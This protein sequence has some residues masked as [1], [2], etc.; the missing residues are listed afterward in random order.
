MP[1]HVEQPV[2]PYRLE[3][4]RKQIVVDHRHI[5]HVVHD[6]LQAT[7]AI[8][9]S[10]EQDDQLRIAVQACPYLLAQHGCIAFDQG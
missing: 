10:F 5:D 7:G 1:D 2:E 6:L 4:E 9:D 3:V 8:I